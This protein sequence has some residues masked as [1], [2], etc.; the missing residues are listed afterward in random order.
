MEGI[1]VS[2]SDDDINDNNSN[3]TTIKTAT[4]TASPTETTT[5]NPHEKIFVSRK[6]QGQKQLPSP[7]TV[8]QGSQPQQPQ[9]RPMRQTSQLSIDS[10]QCSNSSGC[11]E[12][13]FKVTFAYRQHFYHSF[14]RCISNAKGLL[15]N[16]ECNE[17]VW[18]R[19]LLCQPEQLNCL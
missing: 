5:F 17:A 7:A 1:E 11:T 19:S 2:D 16:K 6:T 18:A 14:Q 10:H 4:S 3:A 12:T 8:G 13:S 15:M 9:Q